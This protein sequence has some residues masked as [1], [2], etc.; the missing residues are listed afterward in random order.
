[1]PNQF[2]C[3]I[4]ST[5]FWMFTFTILLFLF[6]I[7]GARPLFHVLGLLLGWMGGPGL[8]GTNL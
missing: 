5:I 2:H 6:F 4:R 8:E 7:F 1:M 3:V